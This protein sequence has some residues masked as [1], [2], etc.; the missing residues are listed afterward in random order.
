M[1]MGEGVDHEPFNQVVESSNS[2]KLQL[3]A[4]LPNKSA[5]SFPFPQNFC[6]DGHKH[7]RNYF[8]GFHSKILG[9]TKKNSR[10]NDG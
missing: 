4:N 8:E 2:F 3:G 7:V 10:E 5:E 6:H 9:K 1:K